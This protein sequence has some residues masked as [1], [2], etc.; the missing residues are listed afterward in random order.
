MP[1]KLHIQTVH[2]LS[3]ILFLGLG[4]LTACQETS[5]PEPTTSTEIRI[6]LLA[7]LSGPLAATTGQ[8]LLNSAR[9]AVAEIND[10][11]GLLIDGQHYPVVLVEADDGGTP[12]T[13]V[14]SAQR[15]INQEN[16]VAI[17]GP[18]FSGTTLHVAPLANEARIPLITPSATNPQITPGRPYVFRTT[19]DDNFQGVAL[20]RFIKDEF[21]ANRAAI[22]YEITNEYS[23]GL[24][25]TFQEAFVD[26]GGEITVV[27]TY[28]ADTNEDFS[29]QLESI[30]QSQVNIL[31]LP[32]YTSDVLQQRQQLQ[33]MGLNPILIGGDSWDGSRLSEDGG[34]AGSYFSGN[35][36]RDLTNEKIRTFVEKFETTYN[37]TPDG[38]ITLTYDTLGLLFAV[39][40][41]ENS[42][43]PDNIQNGLYN[44]VYEGVTG[45]ITFDTDGNPINKAVAIWKIDETTRACYTV[46]TPG[47]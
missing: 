2:L 44:I 1:K 6:G 23:H 47:S 24:A 43:A 36:C 42:F 14:Q 45:T 12:E 18:P 46:V 35:F 20:A 22:L 27:E 9:M 30:A 16:V 5:A 19:F 40:E 38:L 8:A 4:W 17:V 37:R 28:T 32:N 33:E 21:N 7:P 11:G 29:R 15:L 34:F 26:L 13:A 31:F 41:A 10:A 39:M 25:M 3:V